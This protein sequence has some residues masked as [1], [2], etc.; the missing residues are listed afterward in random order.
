M[1]NE[2]DR[3]YELGQIAAK[4]N[5]AHTVLIKSGE[6]FLADKVELA[7]YLKTWSKELYCEAEKER[8]IYDA[9]YQKLGE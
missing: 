4:E 8:A 1:T 7:R 9:K 2:N 6:A 5:F 3:W